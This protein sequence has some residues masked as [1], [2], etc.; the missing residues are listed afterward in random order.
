MIAIFRDI[1]LVCMEQAWC[2]G[3]HC[4]FDGLKLPSNAAKE[5]SGTCDDLQHKKENLA[6]QVRPL[7]DQHETADTVGAGSL[8]E[9]RR[10]EPEQV[11]EPITRRAK[12]AARLAACG[13]AHAPK[14]GTR[15]TALPRQVPANDSANMPTAHGVIQGS[16]GPAVVEANA[17]LS[18]H[19]EAFG[20]GQDYGPVSPRLEGA[21]DLLKSMGLPEEYVAGKRFRAASHS[22]R[23]ANLQKGAQEQLDA[24]SPAPPVR[25]RD[26]RVATQERPQAPT[27]EKVT[28]ADVTDDHEP[29]WDMCPQGQVLT[30]DARR[31]TIEHNIS[32]RYAADAADGGECRRREP[33]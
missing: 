6:A 15:G 28:V 20:N 9:A 5:W 26:P 7:L 17:Q 22:H 27:A 21:K 18:G 29:E 16:N 2:G 23:E 1:L 4:A 12:Q 33:C 8:S 13:A 19:A 25:Q 32:R 3:T 11:P 14:R 31:H 24:D 30:R 10:A